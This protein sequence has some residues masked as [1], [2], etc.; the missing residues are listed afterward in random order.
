MNTDKPEPK[1]RNDGHIVDYS[2]IT[3]NIY[4]GSD[5]CRGTY[6][7][8]HSEEFKKLD[9]RAEINLSKEKKEVPPDEILSYTWIPV[10]DGDTP[11]EEQVDMGTSAINEAISKN[12]NVYVHCKNG[13][14]RSPTMV[15]AYLIRYRGTTLEKAE[16]IIK[17]KRLEI[18]I[19]NIQKQGLR[20]YFEKYNKNG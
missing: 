9:I 16:K 6:C 8:T 3:D 13:H 4:I 18:H 5:L 12:N 15:A 7:P 2:K 19:E 1:G 14:G 20:K 17:E 10:A 11:N